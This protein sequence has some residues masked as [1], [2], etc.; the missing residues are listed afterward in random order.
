MTRPHG[1]T[2]QR[3]CETV[4]NIGLAQGYVILKKR[5]LQKFSMLCNPDNE[6]I[7]T[8]LLAWRKQSGVS[9]SILVATV[10][11]H[12]DITAGEIIV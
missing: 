10:A 7:R 2:C 3:T 6:T 5:E 11:E 12:Y 4:D 1:I 9:T 8:V